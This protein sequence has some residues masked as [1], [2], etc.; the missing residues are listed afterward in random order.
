MSPQ[1]AISH[2]DAVMWVTLAFLATV[3]TFGFHR[4]RA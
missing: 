1:A 2:L 4:G 3:P